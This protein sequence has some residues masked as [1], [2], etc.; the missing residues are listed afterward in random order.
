MGQRTTIPSCVG[1]R[2]SFRL[3]CWPLYVSRRW[4]P[5]GQGSSSRPIFTLVRRPATT[6]SCSK[7]SSR[8]AHLFVDA[9]DT[10][11]EWQTA[12]VGGR[13]VYARRNQVRAVSLPAGFANICAPEEAERAVAEARAAPRMYMRKVGLT[14]AAPGSAAAP[15]R[16]LPLH[17]IRGWLGLASGAAWLDSSAAARHHIGAVGPTFYL[18]L[19]AALYEVFSVS[20]SFGAVFPADHASFTEDVVPLLG[21]GDPSTAHSTLEVHNYSFAIGPR[22]PLLALQRTNSGG[23]ALAAFAEYGWSHI[24][25]KRWIDKCGDCRSEDFNLSGGQFVRGGVDV[26]VMGLGTGHGDCSSRWPIRGIWRRR[27]SPARCA[28]ASQSAPSKAVRPRRAAPD[29]PALWADG[30]G[31]SDLTPRAG[32]QLSGDRWATTAPSK[33]AP[34]KGPSA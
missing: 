26:G 8:A 30:A 12:E 6:P 34:G 32:R 9:A 3:V 5:P 23:W 27:G 18:T 14:T 11:P 31:F 10:P 13:V 17:P 20:A 19:G 21:G 29:I 33:T 4:R 16:F 1:R 15:T 2:I 28:W 25:G 22:T 24:T 7:C